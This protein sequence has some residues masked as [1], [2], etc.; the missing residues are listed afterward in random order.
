MD[1]LL[2]G[3]YCPTQFYIH[4]FEKF[5]AFWIYIPKTQVLVIC[6]ILYRILGSY[7]INIFNFTEHFKSPE[8]VLTYPVWIIHATKQVKCANFRTCSNHWILILSWRSRRYGRPKPK[9]CS[10]W[11]RLVPVSAPHGDFQSLILGLYGVCI[12]LGPSQ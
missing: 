11:Q 9:K 8:L 1:G 7:L 10:F 6:S 3:I 12:W 5:W 2:T 4:I